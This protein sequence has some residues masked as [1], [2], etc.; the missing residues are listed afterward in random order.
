M[1]KIC[2]NC[3]FWEI[4]KSYP[5]SEK[6]IGQ[7]NKVNMFWDSTEWI[8]VSS[9]NIDDSFVRSLKEEYKNDMAFVQDGS[10]YMATFLTLDIFGCNQ[11]EEK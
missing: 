2:K 8:E 10:D 3:K 7:C 9:N 5:I 1:E 4:T 11:F 6:L